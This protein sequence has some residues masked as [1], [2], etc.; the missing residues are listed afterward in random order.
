MDSHTQSPTSYADS[1]L[2]AVPVSEVFILLNRLLQAPVDLLPMVVIAECTE[3]LLKSREGLIG[4][5]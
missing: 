3:C 4:P 2:R 1:Y 5:N